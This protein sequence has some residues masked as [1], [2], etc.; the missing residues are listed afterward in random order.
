ML[1]W[2]G[3]VR[4]EIVVWLDI[5]WYGIHFTIP[6]NIQPYDHPVVKYCLVKMGKLMIRL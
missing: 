2:F 1:V 5:E 4:G 3:G 6:L